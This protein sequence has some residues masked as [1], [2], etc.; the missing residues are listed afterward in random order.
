MGDEPVT[1]GFDRIA[2][3][4]T[5]NYYVF[6]NRVCTDVI[7]FSLEIVVYMGLWDYVYSLC[8]SRAKPE[9]ILSSLCTC[10]RTMDELQCN[11]YPV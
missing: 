10:S 8:N 9:N 11:S 5:E 4:K 6:H 2:G 7:A 3:L 1:R